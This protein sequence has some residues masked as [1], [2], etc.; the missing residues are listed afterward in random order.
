[1]RGAIR[2]AKWGHLGPTIIRI[3]RR[4]RRSRCGASVCAA[5]NGVSSHTEPV[6]EPPLPASQRIRVRYVPKL[7]GFDVLSG[8]RSH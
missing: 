6:G 8:W 3:V 4:K 2:G 1:M 7:S 5:L